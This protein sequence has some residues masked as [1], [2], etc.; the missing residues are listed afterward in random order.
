M[1]IYV[2]NLHW[3]ITETELRELF[4]SIGEVISVAVTI[5]KDSGRSSGFGFVEM[6]QDDGQRAIDALG[7]REIL[8]KVLR[9]S[10]AVEL[11]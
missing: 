9:V 7:G 3:S 1:K 10:E 2:G 5:N 8:S 4:G 6:S 11:P